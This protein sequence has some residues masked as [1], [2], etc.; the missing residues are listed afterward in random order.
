MPSEKTKE[1][2]ISMESQR[3][4]RLMLFNRFG[5]ERLGPMRIIY[6]GL[7]DDEDYVRDSYSCA[8]DEETIE[9]QKDDLLGYVGRAGTS[10]SLELS[11]WRP[12]ASVVARVEVANMIRAS[13]TGSVSELRLFNYSM[14]DVLDALKTGKT[15]VEGAPVALLRCEES[16]QRAMFLSWYS[17]ERTAKHAKTR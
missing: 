12:K 10:L 5:S 14:G 2:N 9:R 13:R 3:F 1:I 11:P 7:L 6:F 16:L 4:P 8:I 15:A 17:Q